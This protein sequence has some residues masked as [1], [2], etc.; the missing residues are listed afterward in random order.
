MP[1]FNSDGTPKKTNASV[2]RANLLRPSL[3]SYFS[4][5]IP[6]P[7]GLT[8][9]YLIANGI[10]S[11]NQEKLNLLCSEAILPGSQVATHDITNDFH[12]VTERHAHRRIYD[13]RID[14]TFYVDSDNYLPIRYFETWIKYVVGEHITSPDGRGVKDPYYS[15]RM[16]YPED[17][18]AEQGLTVKKFDKEYRGSYLQYE[19]INAFP[20]SITSMP[21]SYDT[22]QLLKCTV[23]FSYTRYVRKILKTEPLRIVGAAQNSDG[24]WT[25]EILRGSVIDRIVVSNEE[26]NRKYAPR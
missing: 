2:V 13:D 9:N 19:F 14:F 7:R 21:V 10:L 25:V 3:T 5:S 23:S 15:Y 11:L 8:N 20:I 17:Y 24:T 4:V 6:K 22:S 26:Y 12:G 1:V 18:I 16:N